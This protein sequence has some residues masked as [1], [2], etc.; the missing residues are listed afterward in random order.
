ML[1]E[2]I[3]RP[4]RDHLRSLFVEITPDDASKWREAGAYEYAGWP[5]DSLVT[6]AYHMA[7]ASVAVSLY[8]AD[9]LPDSDSS[10]LI[11]KMAAGVG[12]GLDRWDLTAADPYEM[13]DQP[14]PPEP[15]A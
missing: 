3:G 10:R 4:G 5:L 6:H 9:Q 15:L 1:L 8:A 13:V 12:T 2:A 14:P 11:H 7:R